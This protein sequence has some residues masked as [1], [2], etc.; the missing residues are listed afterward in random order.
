MTNVTFNETN[1][2]F[3]YEGKKVQV[4]FT[5]KEKEK[6]L[7]FFQSA[8]LVQ[9]Q[10]ESIESIFKDYLMEEPTKEL[11]EEASQQTMLQNTGQPLKAEAT[12]EN[13]KSK[14][15]WSV[16]RMVIGILSIL[17]F[18]VITLQSCTAGISN[19]L[20][21]SNSISGSVGFILGLFLL[22]GG[23]TGVATRKS[24][25]KGGCIASSILYA[26]GSV[27]GSFEWNS[28]FSDLRVWVVVSILLSLFYMFCAI[29]TK[30]DKSKRHIVG[31]VIYG[32]L[33]VCLIGGIVLGSNNSTT[34]TSNTDNMSTTTAEESEQAVEK[35]RYPMTI[36][37]NEYFTI[38]VINAKY[39]S[40]FGE[41]INCK[42]T[43]KT[44]QNVTFAAKSIILNGETT[45]DT[46]MMFEADGN[47]SNK[48]NFII[49][50]ADFDEFKDSPVEITVK[51]H[52]YNNDDWEDITEGEF[53]FTID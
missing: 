29:M 3:E 19:A 49:D 24:V 11:K 2:T 22:A 9:V 5:A 33:I 45:I 30:G 37:D 42:F 27:F 35:S 4:P 8:G 13:A 25:K 47:T 34:S 40:I 1:F 15:F 43:N 12:I 17:A 18:I 31:Y 10:E 46:S 36:E 14:A 52:M 51:Y 53:S 6:I 28:T 39:D 21:E 44:D 50:T 38:E 20:E 32:I 26:V 41:Y 23:I 7:P 16:G 48:D